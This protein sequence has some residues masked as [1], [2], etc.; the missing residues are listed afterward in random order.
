MVGLVL[1]LLAVL[2][3]GWS[4]GW[5]R[6]KN[7]ATSKSGNAPLIVKGPVEFAQHSFDPAAPPANMP[8]LGEGEAAECDSDFT[9]DASVAG[10]T[11]KID[12]T[13]AMVTVRQV[14][15][16]LGL[17]INIWV[18]NGAT[19]H[20]I[21]HEE[22]HRQISE[23]YYQNADKVAAQIAAGYIGKMVAVSGSDLEDEARKA[24]LQLSKDITAEYNDKLKPNAAQ[25]RFDDLTDHSR[26]NV[27]ANDAVAQA[28]RET[29]R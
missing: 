25:Q 27:A 15:L 1:L 14:K 26:N 21:E 5:L 13:N 22:G 17:K 29:D 10:V 24:L 4:Q 20:M 8:P 16:T 3:L 12:S 23:H 28:L 7:S 9:S 18:P 6:G 19:Q 2:L 11:H